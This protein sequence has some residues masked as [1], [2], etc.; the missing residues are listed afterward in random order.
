ME[1]NPEPKC[2]SEQICIKHRFKDKDAITL[3]Y[4]LTNKLQEPHKKEC[5]N[6]FIQIVSNFNLT[7]VKSENFLT[8]A[9]NY[10]NK[11]IK[12]KD[13]FRRAFHLQKINISIP[14]PKMSNSNSITS[15]LLGQ[16]EAEYSFVSCLP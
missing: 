14:L 4:Y 11:L 12:I 7:P 2:F 10:L 16:T 15:A 8:D 6:L 13:I 5:H 3:C 1:C 9:C